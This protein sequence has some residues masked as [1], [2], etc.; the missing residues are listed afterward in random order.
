MFLKNQSCIFIQ[1]NTCNSAKKINNTFDKKAM[2]NS[3]ILRMIFYLIFITVISSCNSDDNEINQGEELLGVWRHG[4]PYELGG[5]YT[6][7]F[8][9]DYS[10]FW[11]DMSYFPPPDFEYGISGAASFTWST[12]DN[13]KILII[14]DMKLNTPYSFNAEGQLILNNLRQGK[15]FDKI[16]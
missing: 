16:E 14:P 5:E 1:L 13:P 7:T 12:A 15:P 9:A 4:N 2:K 10:G 6:L 8:Y 11:G 3:R